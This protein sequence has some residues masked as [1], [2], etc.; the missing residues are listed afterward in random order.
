MRPIRTIKKTSVQRFL[1]A[2]ILVLGFALFI[3][4]GT[5]L[6][7]LPMANVDA[8]RLPLLDALFMATSAVSATG[9]T[10]V[11]PGTHFTLFGQ[12]VILVL[13]QIGGLGFMSMTTLLALLLGKKISL[14]ERLVMQE[15]LN[16]PTLSGVVSLS[17]QV[18]E[19]AGTIQLIGAAL[20]AVK[21]VPL[22]GWG[23]GLYYSIFHS[24]SAFNNAGFDLFGE[25]RSLQGFY[26]SALIISV[27]SIL[28]ILGGLG[29]TVILDFLAKRR[30]ATLTLHSK[31][32]LIMTGL[33]LGLGFFTFLVL[34]Y[35]NL[36]TIGR[37]PLKDKVLVSVFQAVV[38]RTAG[39]SVVDCRHLANSTTFF[40]AFLM[41]IG[42]SPGSTGGG[43]KTTTF[44][45][46]LAAAWSVVQG[47]DEVEILGR[48]LP[49][50]IIARAL[51]IFLMGLGIL[52]LG[53]M[54]LSITE[55]L[56]FGEVFFEA[57]S[58]F[59]TT[60]LSTGRTPEISAAGKIILMVLMF[61]GRLGPMTAAVALAQRQR[62]RRKYFR[63]PEEKIIV[64]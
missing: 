54:A 31:M 41:F 9:L 55:T 62:A 5:V 4:V 25:F 42:A 10:V 21:F 58:A 46:L 32:V 35:N 26:D 8:K 64:G 12:L 40:L 52:S 44:G 13:V 16:K 43:I 17:L 48:R 2:Q 61:V 50:Q 56:P 45:A 36:E 49:P 37:L 15:A 53:I 24:V 57:T 11:D 39:F 33:L 7:S 27:L 20:L 63:Y 60:G 19:I 28:V 3:L 1:P 34:E 47:K 59:S 6:L 18:L 38:P 30:F 51:A 22:F 14:R 29:F 23:K